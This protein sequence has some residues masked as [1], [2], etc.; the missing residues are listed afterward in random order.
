MKN[1]DQSKTVW[2]NGITT[3]ILSL[4]AIEAIDIIPADQMV[5]VVLAITILNIILRVW[6]TKTQ[7]RLGKGK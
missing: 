3:L 1:I 5:Y 2:I 6:F 7:I 4:E